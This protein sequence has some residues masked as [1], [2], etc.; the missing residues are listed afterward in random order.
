VR[1]LAAAALS[2]A[3]TAPTAALTGAPGL[4]AAYDEILDARF[5]RV[6]G[7]LKQACPPA[8]DEACLVLT[9][10]SMYWQIL[11]DPETRERDHGFNEATAAAIQATEAWT[12]REPRRAEAWFYLAGSYAPLIQFRVLRGERLAAARDGRRSLDALQHTLDLDPGLADANFGIGLYHYYADVVPAGLKFLRFL[13]LLPG[14]DRVA[15]LR[16]MRL[17][18]A[19]GVLLKGETDYQLQQ[20][21]LW[22]EHQPAEALSLLRGLDGRYP[23]NPLFLERIAETEDSYMHDLMASAAAWQTLVG[24]ARQ[25]DV[26]DAA[27][28]EARARIGLAG[29]LDAMDESDRAVDA[30]LPVV[31]ANTGGV[32]QG[33]W[34]R[35]SLGLARA[36]DRLGRRELAVKAYAGARDHAPEGDTQVRTQAGEGLR[37]TPDRNTTE[38]Y[39]LALD[40]WR[41][42]ERG[43]LDAAASSLGRS[44][45]MNASDPVARYRYARTLA[46]RGETARAGELYEELLAGSPPP[47]F[48]LG[49]V[50]L[51]YARLLERGNDRARAIELYRRAAAATGDARVREEAASALKRLGPS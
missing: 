4:A 27:R 5:D 40:G 22:Y 25:G 34:A 48:I 36:Y 47:S 14:G 44:V 32:P 20:V 11:L 45:A 6:P 24:R 1:G 49:S 17:A 10:A 8:P 51:E 9:A 46:A 29:Q 39:Q 15:G 16:E 12:R 50:Y 2:L 19:E 23:F 18:R 7:A 33:L 21:Y 3:V 30:L 35:A 26:Y 28:V 43:A 37:K 41:A 31:G 42:F 38:A 13:L